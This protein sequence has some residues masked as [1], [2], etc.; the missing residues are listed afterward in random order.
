LWSVLQ[1]E[2]AAICEKLKASEGLLDGDNWENASFDTCTALIE[3][4]ADPYLKKNYVLILGQAFGERSRPYLA[5][6][7]RRNPPPV[8]IDAIQYLFASSFSPLLSNP[9][10]DVLLD[11][12]DQYYPDDESDERSDESDPSWIP[13]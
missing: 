11:Y 10:P 6:L 5:E 13:F 12:Y 7:Q 2:K 3:S 9:E 8:V 4:E 1:N